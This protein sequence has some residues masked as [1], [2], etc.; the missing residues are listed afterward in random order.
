MDR[1]EFLSLLGLTVG[2][3]VAISCLGGCTK[4]DGATPGGNTGGSGGGSLDFTLDL[5]AAENAVLNNNGGFLVKNGVIVA[6]TTGGVYIAVAAA[7][8]HQ[9]TIIQYQGNN[10]RFFCPNHGSTFS[11]SGSV[12]NGPASSDLKQYK[13]EL[14]GKNL[15]VFA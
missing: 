12:L 7:C 4:E 3:G 1:K 11:E 14:S 10:S 6:R 2:G 13:T 9:G 15:R 5:N 8:T